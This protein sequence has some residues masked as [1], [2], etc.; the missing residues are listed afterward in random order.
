MHYV[1]QGKVAKRPHLDLPEGTFE[2]ELGLDGFYGP[3]AHL[4]HSHPP[5]SWTD[6]KASAFQW[7]VR[8]NIQSESLRPQCFQKLKTL[9]EKKKDFFKS[10][11]CLLWNEDVEIGI[12]ILEEFNPE[13]FRNA[14]A[15]ELYFIHEG[16]LKLDS[17]F[18]QLKV[19]SGDYILIPK[20]VS[21]R[22]VPETPSSYILR[23]QNF[24][25][26][27]KKPDTGLMGQQALYHEENIRIP[28]LIKENWDS[29]SIVKV[30]SQ[31]RLSEIHYDFDIRQV[32]GWCG[33][34]YPFALSIHDIAPAMSSMAHLPPS[35][36]T[37]F[38]NPDF[39]VC[40]FLP[41]PLEEPEGALKVPFFHSNIDY[42]EVIFYHEGNFFS[43]DNMGKAYIS[44]H[45]RGIN[46][47]PH[48]KALRNQTQMK[49]TDEVAVMVD[50]RRELNVTAF[51]RSLEERD[52]WKS[53]QSN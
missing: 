4:Y 44:L 22:W 24:G 2:E 37:T 46:H 51:A 10:Y 32:Q 9:N 13:F 50:T 23:I 36:N 42:D 3:V 53:W 27:F 26:A 49:R 31:Y 21:Y 12:Q 35:I 25:A 34:L 1:R 43:R 5:T 14:D 47:G 33:N 8:E 16:E 52:Y 48:P 19:R 7:P 39:V 38:L 40:S 45:P 6:L 15:S 20:G 41:R 18:G 29:N 30:Q 11:R 28:E 17:I